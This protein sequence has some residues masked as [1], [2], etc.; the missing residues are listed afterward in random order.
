MTTGNGDLAV[1]AAQS[2]TINFPLKLTYTKYI[3][4][5]LTHAANTLEPTNHLCALWKFFNYF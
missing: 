5:P 4:Y 1:I 2:H 3:F